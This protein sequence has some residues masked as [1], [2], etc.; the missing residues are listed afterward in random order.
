MKFRDYSPP[1]VPTP[2]QQRDALQKG[3]GRS[4]RWASTG[5]LDDEPLLYAC[6]NDLR[7]D[8][9]CEPSRGQWLWA[10]MGASKYEMR[11]RDPILQALHD[12]TDVPS[13]CQICEI[14][15]RY[16][17]SGDEAFRSRLYEIVE[18]KPISEIPWLGEQEIVNLDG[19]EG[20]LFA[21]RIRGERLKTDEWDW[22]HDALIRHAIDQL[23]EE[24]II[25]ILSDSTE[26]GLQRFYE[27]W[28]QQ[29]KM[30]SEKENAADERERRYS[31]P[32]SEIM[33]AASEKT[34]SYVWFR[35]W[36]MRAEESALNEILAA[37]WNEENPEVISRLL[38]V[39]SNRA[40]PEFDSRLIDLCSHDVEK[41]QWWALSALKNNTHVRVRN[42]A[43]E[44]LAIK[45]TGEVVS[46]FTRN[47]EPGD[48]E[49]ILKAMK[50]DADREKTHRLILSV[51]EVLEANPNADCQKLGVIAYAETPCQIC[52]CSAAKL[53]LNRNVA[54]DW[55][56]EE[57]R[58]DSDEDTRKLFDQ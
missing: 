20:F 3:L 23:G 35:R 11:F 27:C 12:L 42:F 29:E 26:S 47:Y 48:E 34:G 33:E 25:T 46:L 2:D 15:Q 52:R 4:Y 51:I 19:E 10:V 5:K 55:L 50:I 43:L 8:K 6:M 45:A 31:A 53:F 40:L 41:V 14:A 24:R 57:S 17:E 39:F 56:I 7:F 16:A 58:Y 28:K 30:E 1:S 22:D 32:V 13:A 38:R 54:P 9:Q 37:I 18:T 44:Q 49:R 21:A 36:G